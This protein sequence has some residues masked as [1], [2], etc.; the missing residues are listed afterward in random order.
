MTRHG[1]SQARVNMRLI[2]RVSM[3]LIIHFQDQK[4]FR[5]IVVLQIRS[6]TCLCPLCRPPPLVPL[7]AFPVQPIHL[8]PLNP[9]LLRTTTPPL[10]HNCCS[11]WHPHLPSEP[12]SL[13]AQLQTCCCLWAPLLRVKIPPPCNRQD[14]LKP[15]NLGISVRMYVLYVRA[16]AKANLAINRQAPSTKNQID[17][18]CASVI[19]FERRVHLQ[20][21][22]PRPTQTYTLRRHTHLPLALHRSLQLCTCTCVGW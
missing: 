14:L 13:T 12:L 20:H 6:T 8:V 10:Y 22:A 15:A 1:R 7:S 5:E 9:T 19:F 16:H 11:F 3:R 18:T 21:F 17:K 4:I 2:I